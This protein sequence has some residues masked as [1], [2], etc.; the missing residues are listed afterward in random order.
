MLNRKFEAYKITREIKR[1]GIEYE[2]KKQELNEFKES[3]GELKSIGKI[4]G[5][6]HELRLDGR[7]TLTSTDNAQTRFKKLPAIL[8]LYEDAAILNLKIGD[9]V[10]INNKTFKIVDVSNIQEWNIIADIHLEV[11]DYVV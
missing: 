4:K 2:F 11:N 9:F 7:I 10:I 3:V 6:F 8:C 5:L 1:S